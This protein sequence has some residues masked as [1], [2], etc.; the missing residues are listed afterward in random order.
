MMKATMTL[1]IIIADQDYADHLARVA[2]KIKNIPG[3]ILVKVGDVQK[4]SEFT[5]DNEEGFIHYD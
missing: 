2:S 3:V 4:L 5:D 1:K